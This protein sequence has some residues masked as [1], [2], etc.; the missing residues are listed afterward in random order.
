[1]ARLRFCEFKT[2]KGG[3]MWTEVK[4]SQKDIGI[5]VRVGGQGQT[6]SQPYPSTVSGG[7]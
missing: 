1:M 5:S 7:K 3:S 6:S 2:E 4:P